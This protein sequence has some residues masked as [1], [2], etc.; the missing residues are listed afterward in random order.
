MYIHHYVVN[1]GG[2]R[3]DGAGGLG[4]SGVLVEAVRIVFDKL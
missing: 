4:V 3:G 2:H 1:E